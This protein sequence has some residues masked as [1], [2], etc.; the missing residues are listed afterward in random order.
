MDKQLLPRCADAETPIVRDV[1]GFV[2]LLLWSYASPLP[3]V[4]C[5]CSLFC[6]RIILACHCVYLNLALAV[7]IF[8]RALRRATRALNISGSFKI[9]DIV[10]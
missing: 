7:L 8:K 10:A 3:G 9:A 1:V 6:V 4:L 2:E 5:N